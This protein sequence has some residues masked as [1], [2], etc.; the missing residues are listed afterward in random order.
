MLNAWGKKGSRSGE[1]PGGARGI[2]NKDNANV[3]KALLFFDRVS[4]ANSRNPSNAMT[5]RPS[6]GSADPRV[7]NPNPNKLMMPRS[8]S[9]LNVSGDSDPNSKWG[10]LS[11]N[12]AAATEI[13]RGSEALLQNAGIA[14]S[15][16]CL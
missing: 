13:N 5:E 14:P 12:L 4:N 9:N 6:A 8:R 2:T 3:P 15:P 16:V 11:H 7:G 10:N 1:E